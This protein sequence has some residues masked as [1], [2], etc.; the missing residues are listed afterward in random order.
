M[1]TPES[2]LQ[3]LLD[4]LSTLRAQNIMLRE[5]QFAQPAR[6]PLSNEKIWEGFPQ[7]LH[8]TT[9]AFKEGVRW[10]EAQHKIGA[11]DE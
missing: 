11:D 4:E 7:H 3:D 5:K 1:S 8:V 6:E 9:L 10:A 2:M